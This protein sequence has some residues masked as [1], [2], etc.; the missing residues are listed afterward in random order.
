VLRW[1]LAIATGLIATASIAQVSAT[2]S[3]VSEYRFRGVSLSQGDPAAQLDLSY[4]HRSGWYAGAFG[5]NVEF[6]PDRR[7]AQLTGYAGYSRRLP[8]G[9]SLDAGAAY[10]NFSGGDGYNY[11]ELDAG[12]TAE[13]LSGHLYFSPNYFGQGIH[14]LYAEL[15]ASHP[16]AQRIKLI[17]HAGV[18]QA[19]S[20]AS[21]QNGGWRPHVDV[22]AGIEVQVQR[23]RLQLSRV[24]NDGISPV[25]PVGANHTGGVWTVRLSAEF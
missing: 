16:L 5:S 20:G 25:Y 6:D 11:L 18:L 2:A 4:D 21:G 22:Q 7:E 14:T 10:S 23:L 9:L 3:L 13:A 24:V 1:L 12:F 8:S 19:L 17:G 15:N